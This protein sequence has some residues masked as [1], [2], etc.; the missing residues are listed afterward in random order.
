MTDKVKEAA[1]LGA[2]RL[3]NDEPAEGIKPETWF[4]VPIWA[5]KVVNFERHNAHLLD[6][7]AQLEKETQSVTRSNV[8]GWHS[9]SNLHI[10]DRLSEIRQVIGRT[11][12]ECARHMAFD[13]TKADLIFQEMWINKNGPGDFNKAHVHPNAVLSG[14]Y[15]VNVPAESGNIEF[16]DPVRER[17]MSLYPIKK[18]TKT[19]SQ[20]LEYRCANG[21]LI[22]FPSWLQ[23]GVQPNRSNDYRVSIAFNMGYRPKPPR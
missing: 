1:A 15:Y 14:S 20:A 19:N 18:R 11:C 16:F 12:V 4:S 2:R 7:T 8:G 17:V 6:V 10:D 3:D 21:L 9:V 22:I 13:F 5:R 23:H